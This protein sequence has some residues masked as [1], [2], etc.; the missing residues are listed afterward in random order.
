MTLKPLRSLKSLETLKTLR[1]LKIK[2]GIN[3]NIL[4]NINNNFPLLAMDNQ[5]AQRLYGSPR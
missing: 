2:I 4:H 1:S 3:G 5:M